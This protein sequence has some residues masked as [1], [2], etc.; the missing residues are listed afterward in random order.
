MNRD[1]GRWRD[2]WEGSGGKCRYNASMV[3]SRLAVLHGWM[4]GFVEI[5]AALP[6]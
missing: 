4:D 3:Q 5:V 2:G 6:H 1:D